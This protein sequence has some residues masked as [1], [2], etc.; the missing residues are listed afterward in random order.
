MHEFHFNAAL[1]I[2]KRYHLE[3]EYYV[4]L[5]KSL[6]VHKGCLWNQPDGERTGVF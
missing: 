5:R 1:D 3:D 6:I 2:A 4:L